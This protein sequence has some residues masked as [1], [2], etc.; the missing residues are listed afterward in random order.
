MYAVFFKTKHLVCEFSNEIIA[1]D[2][3]QLLS[4]SVSV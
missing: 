2:L 4:T 1:S 3:L